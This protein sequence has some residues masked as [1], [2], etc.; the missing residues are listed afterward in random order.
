MYSSIHDNYE[1]EYILLCL[2][3]NLE[4]QEETTIHILGKLKHT[5]T[6]DINSPTYACGFA[7]VSFLTPNSHS[8]VECEIAAGK[9]C[10]INC[11]L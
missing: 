1:S 8:Q 10:N 11:S 5:N 7:K 9:Q 2:I 4:K 3:F 6:P